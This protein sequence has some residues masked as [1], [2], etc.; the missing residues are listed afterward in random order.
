MFFISRQYYIG[1]LRKSIDWLMPD[2]NIHKM[3]D[4]LEVD[5]IE[6]EITKLEEHGQSM[7]QVNEETKKAIELLTNGVL[8]AFLPEMENVKERINELK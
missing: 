5:D 7:G 8:S 6:K 4:Q 2:H 3:A 1:N